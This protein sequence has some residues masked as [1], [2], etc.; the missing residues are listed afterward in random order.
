[1]LLTSP[2]VDM[3]S[4]LKLKLFEF[5]KTFKE[6]RKQVETVQRTN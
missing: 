6:G 4:C 3:Y 2:F 1:M 5:I